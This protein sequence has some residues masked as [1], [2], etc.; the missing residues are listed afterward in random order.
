MCF[1]KQPWLVW[2]PAGFLL[3]QAFSIVLIMATVLKTV[4]FPF[5]LT[6]QKAAGY[7]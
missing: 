4:V 2:K 5:F 3:C 1:K 7:F 6:N